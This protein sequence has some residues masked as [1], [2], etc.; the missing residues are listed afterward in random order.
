ME[1]TPLLIIGFGDPKDRKVSTNE[2]QNAAQTLNCKFKEII[3]PSNE[4]APPIDEIEET[5]TS[6]I[7]DTFRFYSIR[8]ADTSNLSSLT[9]RHIVRIYFKIQSNDL[10]FY[11]LFYSVVNK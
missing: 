10:L 2:G 9:E 3:L 4:E 6:F 1:H 7:K 8:E 11:L 5:F